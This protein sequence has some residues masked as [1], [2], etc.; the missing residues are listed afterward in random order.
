MSG[1][2]LATGIAELVD[3][4]E[5]DEGAEASEQTDTKPSKKGTEN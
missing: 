4:A 2:I 3:K 1:G 5:I